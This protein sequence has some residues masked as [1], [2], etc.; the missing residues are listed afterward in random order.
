MAKKSA[1]PV[2][3]PMGASKIQQGESEPYGE[4][5]RIEAARREYQEA[6]REFDEE[7]ARLKANVDAAYK[8]WRM[9]AN[10]KASA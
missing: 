4:D 1:N 10:R 2:G 7:T 5:A 3:S 8:A 9:L 6:R